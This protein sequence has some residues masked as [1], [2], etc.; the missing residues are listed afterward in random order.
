MTT[1]SFKILKTNFTPSI[2]KVNRI[3]KNQTQI[4]YK[5]LKILK[6]HKVFCWTLQSYKI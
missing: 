1:N 3:I 5:K 6:T 4:Q 2:K